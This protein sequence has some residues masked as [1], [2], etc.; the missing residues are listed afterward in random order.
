MTIAKLA[1][2]V[3]AFIISACTAAPAVH[4]HEEQAFMRT[5][6]VSGEGRAAAA[7]DMAVISIGVQNE[8]KTASEALRANSD[9]MR[10]T[11]K[12][13]KD[14]DVA[15]KDIQTSGLSVNP[16]YDYQKNRSN[17]PIVGYTASNTV[18][19][20]LRDLD[21]A[22]AVIDQA[23]QSGANNLGGISFTFAEPKP[24]YEKARKDAV[25]D[26]KAKAELLTD[27]A[28][29]KLGRLVTI[30]DGYAQAPSPRPMMARMEA[31]ADSSVPIA[32]GESVVT[33]TV[34]MVYE[35]E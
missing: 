14:L 31:S 32:A 20:R 34:N 25:K 13:L 22:G 12:K 7:P 27:A 9:A 10:A 26:A 21:D 18:T 11:I 1:L 19:V 5:I 16:R 28:G 17:P 24:L 4:A 15:D 29:V 35:I 2:P 8:G 30:Q 3:A 33:A 6:T 23:V